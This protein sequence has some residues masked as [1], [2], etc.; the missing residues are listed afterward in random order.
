M[1]SS[2]HVLPADPFFRAFPHCPGSLLCIK[3]LGIS[4]ASAFLGHA[5]PPSLPGLPGSLLCIKFLGISPSSAFLSHV[6]PPSIPALPEPVV[7]Y[8]C[9]IPLQSAFSGR[10]S[11]LLPSSA[12]SSGWS[13]RHHAQN[14]PTQSSSAWP[15]ASLLPSRPPSAGGIVHFLPQFSHPVTWPPRC[16]EVKEPL[17]ASPPLHSPFPS[18][19]KHRVRACELW[20]PIGTIIAPPKLIIWPDSSTSSIA[21]VLSLSPFVPHAPFFSLVSFFSLPTLSPPLPLL[22]P[23]PLWMSSGRLVPRYRP[24]IRT[25][26]LTL[27]PMV[28]D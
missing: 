14:S 18:R 6:F 26:T 22:N 28:A 1:N 10:D 4:P 8:I 11:S 13:I 15:V 5:F 17:D 9:A 24:Q 3:F 19:L 21:P 27:T 2:W 7:P 23:P 16:L 12:R 25:P 20:R